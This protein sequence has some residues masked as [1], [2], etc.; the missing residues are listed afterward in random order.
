M[1]RLA[2]FEPGTRL[3]CAI[4]M[5]NDTKIDLIRSVPLFSRLGRRQLERVG[6][7]ADEVD[8][9]A[10]RVLTR[11]GNSGSEMFVLVSGRARVE[12]DGR[13]VAELGPG[14]WIGEMA[15][16]SEG[17]RSATVITTE[18]ARLLVVAHR[19]FHSLMD[20]MPEVRLTVLEGLAQRIRS[21]DTGSAH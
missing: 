17:P 21:M 16:L 10:G 5:G 13:L 18:P 19:E 4:N 2:G 11:Q 1:S 20:E 14:A 8:V 7:L 9:P 15:L 6:Q 3:C 12:R